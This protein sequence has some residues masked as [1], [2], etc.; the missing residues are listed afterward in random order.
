MLD[1]KTQE[2][3]CKIKKTQFVKMDAKASQITSKL[4]LFI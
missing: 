3:L 2:G 1:I 4:N